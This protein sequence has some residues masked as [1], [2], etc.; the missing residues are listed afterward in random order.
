MAYGA[1]C[2]TPKLLL[3][4][5]AA[6]VVV[7]A[8]ILYSRLGESFR[9]FA[10]LFFTPDLSI[11]GYLAG[12]RTGA[13]IYNGAHSYIAPA[14]MLGIAYLTNYHLGLSIALIWLAHIGLDRMLGFGLKYSTGFTDTHLGRI[15]G[16]LQDNPRWGRG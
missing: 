12:R 4:L 5:E 6:A 7:L 16:E 13:A 2:G 9:W 14:L 3:R 15:G 1:V 8:V 11:A 10:L